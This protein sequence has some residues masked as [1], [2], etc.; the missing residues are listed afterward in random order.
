MDSSEL[1]C[2]E[3]GS[4]DSDTPYSQMMTVPAPK[5]R[6]ATNELRPLRVR[7]TTFA[8]II[9]RKGIPTAREPVG[10]LKPCYIET[11]TPVDDLEHP[12]EGG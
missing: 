2:E 10:T 8:A 3:L 12:L 6:C 7:I 11:E 9:L 1:V 4:S 5:K